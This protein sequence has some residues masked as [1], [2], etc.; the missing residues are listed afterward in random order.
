RYEIEAIVG[1]TIYK[2]TNV[3]LKV[4]WTD[5]SKPT[6]VDEYTFQEDCPTMLYSYWRSHG[7]REKATGIKSFHAFRI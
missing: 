6:L 4:K 3:K 2:T 7:T 1:H 5:D